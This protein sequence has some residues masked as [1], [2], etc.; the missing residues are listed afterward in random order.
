VASIPEPRIMVVQDVD[1]KSG[2]GALVGEPHAL[3][4]LAIHCFGYVTNGSVR[5]LPAVETLGFHL[6]SR[7]V[8][9]SHMY[10]HI[11]EYGD[12]VEIGGLK[13]C[14]DDL[15]H[16]DRHGVHFIPLSIASKIPAMAAE[17]LREER[18]LRELCRS[19]KFSL[20]ALDKKLQHLPGD[21]FELPLTG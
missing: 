5:D 13:I 12:P 4:G 11:S 6:F 18:E 8:A 16:G 21:G 14:P 19:P 10:A 15:I 17:I 3:I 20:R 2:A 1:E 9:V 7:G